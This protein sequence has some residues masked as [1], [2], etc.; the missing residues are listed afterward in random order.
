M[1]SN[2]IFP[3]QLDDT[4]L[5]ANTHAASIWTPDNGLQLVGNMAP[6]NSKQN[7]A[8]TITNLNALSSAKLLSVQNGPLSNIGAVGG[9]TARSFLN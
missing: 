4:A 1:A 2:L 8:V 5:V 6:A 3:P 7:A 9:A